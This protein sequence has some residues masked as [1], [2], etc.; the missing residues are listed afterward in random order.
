MGWPP[1]LCAAEGCIFAAI[2]TETD[3]RTLLL[4][5][6]LFPIVVQAQDRK[7]AREE[8]QRQAREMVAVIQDGGLIVRLT[9]NARKIAGMQEVLDEGDL[10]PANR[11]RLQ[12]RLETTLRETREKQEL[13][14]RLMRETYDLGPLY[15]IPDTT[16]TLLQEGRP[17]GYFLN[18]QLEVDPDI[19]RPDDFVVARIGY[20]NAATTAR[21]DA[22]I[23][24]D[25][26][27]Q[28]L[29]SPFPNAITFNN[30]GYVLNSI[31]APDIAERKR[32]EGMVERLR[33]KLSAAIAEMKEEE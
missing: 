21:A 17:S 7:E 30:L 28:P 22:L 29:P 13:I 12:E 25:R 2:Y 10:S 4:L 15:F 6:L 11:Q 20:T 33:N 32:M 16:L 31:L 3:M 27:D 19:M 9:T 26:E 1:L 5:V 23:L 18:D 8:E 24:R 14:V